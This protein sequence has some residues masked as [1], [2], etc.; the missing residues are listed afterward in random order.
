MQL[1]NTLLVAAS[2]ALVSAEDVYLVVKSDNSEINGNT[3]GFPHSGAGL[4]YAYLGTSAQSQVLDYDADKKLLVSTEAGIPQSFT[5][6]KYVGLT[7]NE[8]NDQFTF[9]DKNTLLVNGSPDN[10]YACKNTGDPYNYSERSYELMYYTA[11]AP[12][13]C[14][15]LTLAKEGDAQ[16]TPAPSTPAPAPTQNS[17][18]LTQTSTSTECTQCVPTNSDYTGGAARVN[19]GFAGAMAVLAGA[20]ALL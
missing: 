7:V 5:A 4:N 10:F 1:R 9:D 13:G 8:N 18:T 2:A 17:T 20:A 6:G 16:P 14:I 19:G 15:G 3:L 12:E 11:D